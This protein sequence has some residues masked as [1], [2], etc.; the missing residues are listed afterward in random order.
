[1]VFLIRLHAVLNTD[2]STINDI[3]ASHSPLYNLCSWSSI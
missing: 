2:L 3:F 1:L